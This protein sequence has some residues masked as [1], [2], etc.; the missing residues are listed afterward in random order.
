MNNLKRIDFEFEVAKTFAGYCQ[1]PFEEWI[2]YA[3][4]VVANDLEW[5]KIE[6]GDPE[7]AWDAEAAKELADIDI[8]Y[9][10]Y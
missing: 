10:E 4:E 5:Q 9:W 7:Y 2:E 8:S 3:Q 1:E 6:Y